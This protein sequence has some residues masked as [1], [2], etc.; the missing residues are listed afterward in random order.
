MTE[1]EIAG[2]RGMPAGQYLGGSVE[3]SQT[4][5]PRGASVAGRLSR[6]N[7]RIII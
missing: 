2:H 1:A 5:G 6:L 7:D 3:E 4:Q